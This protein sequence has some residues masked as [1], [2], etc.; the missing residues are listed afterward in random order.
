MPK[1]I[2]QETCIRC[3][4]CLPECPNEGITEAEDG[5][6][7]ESGMCSECFGFYAQ[8]RCME[9]CPVEAVEDAEEQVPEEVLVE[10]AVAHRPEHFPRD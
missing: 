8:S 7:I 10:R 1:L 3:G 4:I 2:N 5:Y 6:V 9:V